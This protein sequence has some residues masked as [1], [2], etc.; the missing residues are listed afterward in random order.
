MVDLIDRLATYTAGSEPIFTLPHA[1]AVAQRGEYAHIPRAASKKPPGAKRPGGISLVTMCGNLLHD[2]ILTDEPVGPVCGTCHG[3]QLGLAGDAFAFRPRTWFSLPR[4]WCRSLG[5]VDIGD[6]LARCLSCGWVGG[7]WYSGGPWGGSV[8]MRKHHHEGRG[9]VC[10]DHGRHHL[11]EY[12]GEVICN[13]YGCEHR[14]IVNFN[15]NPERE[16]IQ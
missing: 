16:S 10:P 1:Y 9:V 11:M 6:R 7:T 2:P 8:S 4:K 5:Y 12:R 3:R 15:H 14:P 13:A